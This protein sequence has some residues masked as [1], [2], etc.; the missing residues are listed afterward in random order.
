MKIIKHLQYIIIISILFSANNV[1]NCMSG[2][3]TYKVSHLDQGIFT[4]CNEGCHICKEWKLEDAILNSSNE[5]IR[6]IYGGLLSIGS[7]LITQV[8]HVSKEDK[9]PHITVQKNVSGKKSYC[10][11]Y[12]LEKEG[13]YI[14]SC[15]SSGDYKGGASLA[16]AKMT[17]K[18]IAELGYSI[19]DVPTKKF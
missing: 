7:M 4:K 17:P 12:N 2:A 3:T 1:S 8:W 5:D 19:K 15:I 9:H 11:I 13:R 6:H 16:I 18:R 10:H 14:T